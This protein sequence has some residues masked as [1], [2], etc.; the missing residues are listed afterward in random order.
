MHETNS[1]MKFCSRTVILITV[2]YLIAGNNLYAQSWDFIKEKNGIKVYTRKVAN[3][4]LK[5]FKGEVI[6]K[7]NAEKIILFIGNARNTDWWD[8]NISLVKVLAFEENKFIRYYIVYAVPWP[9]SSRDLIVE[10][11]IS[12]DPVTGDRTVISKAVANVIP[13]KPGLVRIKNYTQKW[14][15]QTLDK[16]FVRVTLEGFV[17]PGG[18]I[19]SWLYNPFIT[20][21]PLNVMLAL[22]EKVSTDKAGIK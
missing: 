18:Y 12:T 11:I 19:P 15:V 8:K 5:S 21:T 17:D 9:I 3:S 20:D 13:E 7:G 6:F 22:R 4:P 10:A 2:F 1:L 14:T 16:G